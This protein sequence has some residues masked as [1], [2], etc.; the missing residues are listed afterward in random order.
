MDFVRRDADDPMAIGDVDAPVVLSEWI[1]LRCPFCAV[2]SRETMPTL[3]E[4]YVDAGKVRI[5]FHDVAYFGEESEDAAVAARAAARQDRF[6]EFVTAVYDAAPE[7][8]HPDL[9]RNELIDFAEEAGVTDIE[10]F[11]ADLED[12]K[13][14][15]EVQAST[16][17]AQQ[18]GVTA[19]PFFV[20]GDTALSG[21][22]PTET[23]R[24]LLDEALAA[25]E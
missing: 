20:T 7:R 16:Q 2:V 5:E 24:E 8:G 3:M 11:T 14:R 25:G 15:A 23:F 21:A 19:V 6:V 10:K 18:L 9:P 4:E 17:S 13:L 12:P 1:D 22:Q